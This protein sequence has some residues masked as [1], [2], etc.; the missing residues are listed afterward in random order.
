MRVACT[1]L[2]L[3]GAVS[4]CPAVARAQTVLTLAEVLA[5]A[6]AQAPQIVSARLA[7]DEARGRLVG[8]SLRLQSNPELDV[9]LGNRRN[10]SGRSTDVQFGIS[11]MFESSG[12]RAA[13]IAGAT[14]QL[15][16]GS[17]TADE[18]TR[19]VLRD[20]AEIFYQAVYAG[21]RLRLSSASVDLA[22]AVYQTADRRFRAGDL[23]VLDVN[24]ARAALGRARAD[25]EADRADQAAALG[26][27]QALLLIEGPIALQGSLTLAE[28]P[29]AAALTES[30]NQR[31]ELRGLE[32]AVREADADIAV[33]KSLAKPGYGFGLRYQREGD[34]HIVLGG[35]V[36]ALPVFAKGQELSA[37]GTARGARLR[38]ELAAARV[39][40]RIELQT[41]LTAYERRVVAVRMLEA[42]ALP[43]LDENDA[44]TMRSFEVGQI[45]LPEVLLIRHELLETRS[46]YLSALLE[47]AL[48][49]V[50]LDA[51]AAV[52]R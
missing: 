27:L 20:A 17:A 34:D 8:A 1:A 9:N 16:E 51:T 23:A 10:P 52:L 4:L 31:P 7:L 45:G 47:A 18:R 22:N 13:R 24:V 12:R 2:A 41:A 48:A 26:A 21:E 14:A 15:D 38:A 30:V 29:D 37:T 6:R 28:A 32:A 46:Q 25:L 11:Q 40:V 35:L 19:D 39:R 3:S 42:D 44:L 50:A 43:G 49:R 5:R 36:V 33:S